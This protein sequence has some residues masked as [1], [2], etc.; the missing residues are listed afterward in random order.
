MERTSNDCHPGSRS[1][2]NRRRQRHRPRAGARACGAGLRPGAGRSRRSGHAAR[3]CGD[4]L[5]RTTPQA[6]ALR[7]IA[8]I[9][10][11]QPR[12]LIGNDARFMDLLQRLR[13]ATYWAPLARMIEKMAK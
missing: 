12:I 8:G 3:R 10:K 5:A 13:A 6:A 2:L 4:Q 7:I 11:N 9:E 1:S